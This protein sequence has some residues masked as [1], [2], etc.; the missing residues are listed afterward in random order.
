MKLI[1][2]TNILF[3]FFWDNSLAKKLLMKINLELFSPEFALEEI[4]KYKED[5]L[6]KTGISEKQFKQHR[7]DIAIAVEFIPLEEYKAFLKQAIKISPDQND[8]DFFALALKL[9][10]PIWSNDSLLKK[11]NKIKIFSTKDL[12][13]KKEFFEAIE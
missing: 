10:L 12:L 6:E 2:D 3:T 1:V 4:N 9:K 13:E 8:I 11:Q 7:R 5:I